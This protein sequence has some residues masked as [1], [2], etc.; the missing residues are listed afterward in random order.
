MLKELGEIKP[1][2]INIEKL[3]NWKADRNLCDLIMS[4]PVTL[5]K[6]E[7]RE[8][9]RRNQA[10]ENQ[11]IK[12]LF[13]NGELVGVARLMFINSEDSLAEI[14]LY[15]GGE[16]TRGLG[17][18]TLAL[19]Q[20]EEIARDKWRLNKLYARILDSNISSVMLFKGQGYSREGLLRSHYRS[21]ITS[22]WN[23]IIYLAKFI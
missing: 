8:W 11:E 7:T 22:K 2:D 4:K 21:I 5:S 12:G 13:L 16:N 6:D 14:G 3:K 1:S 19:S 20:L 15:I 10:D 17:L 18:G 23:D 9:L